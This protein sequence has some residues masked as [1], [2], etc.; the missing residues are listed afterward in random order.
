MLNINQYIK[1]AVSN[2]GMGALCLRHC[3]NNALFVKKRYSS[4]NRGAVDVVNTPLP[5]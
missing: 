3:N 4:R 1:T 5:P 2:F